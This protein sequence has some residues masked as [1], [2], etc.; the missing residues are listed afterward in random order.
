MKARVRT[1][2]ATRSA[3]RSAA[4]DD[5][6]RRS[7]APFSPVNEVSAGCHSAERDLA[8]RGGVAGHR[9]DVEAGEP[10]RRRLGLGDRGRGEHERGVRAVRRADPAQ[11]AQHLGDVRPED[12][13]VVVALVDHDEGELGEEGAPPLVPGQQRVVQ[14]VGVGQDVLGVVARPGA[15][16]A[17]AVA[18]VGG[19]PDVEAERGEPGQLVLGER[20]GRRQVERGRPAL[21]ARTAALERRGQRGE[22]VG[23]RL[24]GRGAG[25]EHDVLP[26]VRR[27]G[28]GRLVL[29]RL[30]DAAGP[31]RVDDRGRRPGRP[32]CAASGPGGQPLE[33]GEPALAARHRGQPVHDLGH[34]P[35]PAVRRGHRGHGA[36][37]TNPADG[38]G[39]RTAGHHRRAA[40]TI[41]TSR[42]GASS[43]CGS[44]LCTSLGSKW[45]DC[46][47]RVP[48]SMMSRG[49]A[50]EL[51]GRTRG[52]DAC[53]QRGRGGD[54][55]RRRR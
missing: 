44:D 3:S 46:A 21:A 31:E 10:G 15:L 4:S 27:V 30:V 25:G 52:P 38:A 23:Q 2:S 43:L 1:P 22:L 48:G 54:D 40:R 50:P 12:P 53:D 18:V 45:F 49:S 28:R 7:G 24:A 6:A 11:P 41:G 5:A 20:L 29:P 19:D 55:H 13:A 14:H 8:P 47:G 26:G 36:S 51:Q 35:V 9:Q 32:R 39:R 16:V 17:A 42:H 33:V 37:M 34:R